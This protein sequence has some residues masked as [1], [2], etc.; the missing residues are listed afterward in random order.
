ML[1][2]AFDLI[3][4]WGFEYKTVAFH[5]AKLNRSFRGSLFSERDFFTGLGYCG[6]IPSSACSP[7][8]AGRRAC[9]GVSS[10]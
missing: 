9:R 8:P 7:P 6:P 10:G 3:G 4:A 5:W 2:R 1:P